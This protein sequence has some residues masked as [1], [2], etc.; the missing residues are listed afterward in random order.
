MQINCYFAAGLKT[1]INALLHSVKQLAE[2]KIFTTA[3]YLIVII[4]IIIVIVV[5]I[6]II[7]TIIIIIISIVSVTIGLMKNN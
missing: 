7:I 2:V 4:T 5:F 6:V 1:I 3:F